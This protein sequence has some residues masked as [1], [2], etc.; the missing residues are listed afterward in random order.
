MRPILSRLKHWKLHPFWGTATVATLGCAL[1]LSLG[2][3]SGH[4]GFL[5][6]SVGAFQAAQSNPLHRF[7]MLRMLLLIVLGAASVGLG[8]WSA[9]EPLASLVVFASGGLLLAWFQRF[10]S[11]TGKLGISML[12]CLCLGQGQQSLGNTPNPYAVAMLFTLGGLWV[13]LL[14]FGL[15]GL[16]GL[17]MWPYTPRLFSVLKVLRRHANRLPQQEWRMYAIG[18]TLA[19]A[20]A[21]LLVNLAHLPRSYWLSL[22]LV[23]SLQMDFT[24][25]L[26]RKLQVALAGLLAAAVLVLI[27]Y[28]LQNP[29]QMVM[30]VLP[31][32]LLNRA[33]QMKDYGFFVMQMTFC[34]VLLTESLARDW[35]QYQWRLINS[36]IG[37]TLALLVALLVYG[38][39]LL[40]QRRAVQLASAASVPPEPETQ[41]RT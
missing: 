39:H 13:A 10:G 4:S 22:A 35:E 33:F 24:D 21:G 31:L 23:A 29:S 37:V 30:V 14:A 8:F 6:A 7:G 16:H 17:R 25:R 38:V 36:L 28:S 41:P 40:I 3:F 34:F 15:R 12:V 18:C 2:L 32:I 27:G 26:L 5:W 19:C 20:L 11:E 9:P 1:P